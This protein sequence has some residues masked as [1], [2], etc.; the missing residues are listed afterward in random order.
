MKDIKKDEQ[1]ETSFLLSNNKTIVEKQQDDDIDISKSELPMCNKILIENKMS[2]LRDIYKTKEILT[3]LFG[4]NV[5]IKNKE[6]C[7]C[8]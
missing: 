8:I 7:N 2:I 5:T 3:F 1:H 4:R 6:I